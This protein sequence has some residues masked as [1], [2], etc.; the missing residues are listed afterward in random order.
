MRNK[1]PFPLLSLLFPLVHVT[2]CIH[3]TLHVALH[4]LKRLQK[5]KREYV[6]MVWAS[7]QERIGID[8]QI[9]TYLAWPL[10]L[11]AT[12]AFED[13]RCRHTDTTRN[14]TASPRHHESDTTRYRTASPSGIFNVPQGWHWDPPRI[15]AQSRLDNL[16]IEEVV[17]GFSQRRT[18]AVV[19]LVKKKELMVRLH[20]RCVSRVSFLV[21]E[22][23][24]L[25]GRIFPFTN[26]FHLHKKQKEMKFYISARLS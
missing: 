16:G 10:H 18:G 23:R 7:L 2:R 14:R 15:T 5:K 20:I 8:E 24:P 4:F 25:N 13:F 11:E 3:V 12:A 21:E 22:S 6:G 1:R 9:V 17:S 26:W 19:K